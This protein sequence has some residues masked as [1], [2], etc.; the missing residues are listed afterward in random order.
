M[1]NPSVTS[2]LITLLLSAA[3][4]AHGTTQI[5]GTPVKVGEKYFM[6]PVKT[7]NNDG[8]GLVPAATNILPSCPLG[9]TQTR[10]PNQRGIPVSF[11]YTETI[12]RDYVTTDTSINIEFMSMTPHLPLSSVLTTSY[13]T[14]GTTPPQLLVTNDESKTLVVQ[15]VKADDDA[16]KAT[17]RVEKLG[18]RMFPFY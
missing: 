5:D 1:K 17:S 4:C 13:G 11:R 2:F 15:F 6:L 10:L 12:D 8:G 14:V 3:V 16:T 18:L 7:E 9:I